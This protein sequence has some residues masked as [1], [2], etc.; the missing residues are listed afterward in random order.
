MN[1]HYLLI[2]NVIVMK[3]LITKFDNFQDNLISNPT[4]LS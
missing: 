4:Q 1:L 2:W 3:E